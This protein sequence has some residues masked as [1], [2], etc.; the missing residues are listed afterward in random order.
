[1]EDRPPWGGPYV[2]RAV[3]K[4]QI[5][6]MLLDQG[7][8]DG[9]ELFE[10]LGGKVTWSD[11]KWKKIYDDWERTDPGLALA[12]LLTDKGRPGPL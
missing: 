7:R 1:M 3:W 10:H 9:A 5:L 11:P 8:Y 6:A 12:T 2:R 4:D